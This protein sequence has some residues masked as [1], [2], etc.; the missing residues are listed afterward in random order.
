MMSSKTSGILILIARVLIGAMFLYMCYEKA[1]NMAGTLAFMQ[2]AG[3]GSPL[4]GWGAALIE[5][6][7]G[8]MLIVGFHAEIAA[9]MLTLFLLAVTFLFHFDPANPMQL[10]QLTKNLAIVGGLLM[11]I[12]NC[13]GEYVAYKCK[14]CK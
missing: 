14:C 5:G 1:T 3:I 2:S 13:G 12:T 8:L 10:T 9:V 7:G 6:L 4:F 11:I